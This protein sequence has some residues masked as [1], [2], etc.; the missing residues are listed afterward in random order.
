MKAFNKDKA[1]RKIRFRQNKNTYI[2]RISI[3]LSCVI[4]VVAIMLFTFAKFESTAEWTLIDGTVTTG[5]DANIIAIY[6]GDTKVDTI[7]AKNSGWYFDRAECTN[8]AG[9]AWDSD[10][11][12]LLL[13][14]NTKT[15][16]T[17]Y[18]KNQPVAH[19][20]VVSGDLHTVGSVVKIANEEFYVIGHEDSTHV[21][22][23]SKWNLNVGSNAKP[24]AELNLQDSDVRGYVNS[25]TPGYVSGMQKYGNVAFS[26]TN[27]WVDASNNLLS[28]YDSSYPAY[29]YDSNTNIKQYVDTY[30]TYLT[31]Q[32]INVS[33]RLIKQEELVSLGCNA[34]KYYCDSSGTHGGTA[35]EWVYQ[36]AYWSGSAYGRSDLWRVSSDGTFSNYNYVHGTYFGVRPVIIL[37]V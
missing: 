20:T 30:V 37:E 4:L 9:A 8:G 29:V 33:G 14:S 1:L 21:K 23:L 6:Q 32:G 31:N 17:I 24:T 27:Y 7:P 28:T 22:L 13:S 5:K 10:R 12:L 26:S 18:F 36:T 35:P 11:W 19:Y 16:C 34:S 15:K 2:K 25:S 3:V